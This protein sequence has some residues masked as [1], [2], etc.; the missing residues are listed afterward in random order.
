MSRIFSTT[1]FSL[2]PMTI[3]QNL[4][5]IRNT[6]TET[7]IDCGR[8][9][10]SIKLVAVS[11]RHSIACIEEAMAAKQYLFGE[12]YIQEAQE[13]IDS[14]PG[15]DFHFIGHIQSNKAKIAAELFSMIETVDRYKL[16]KA[17]NKHLEKLDREL[18]ILIQVNIGKDLNK[19][20]IAPEKTGE[21]L[22]QIRSFSRIHPLG[23]MTIP[24]FSTDNE[25]TRIHFQNL[26]LLSS[27][28]AE[29]GLF[30][31]NTKVELSMGMSHDYKIAIA[32]GA[33]II[34]VGTAIFGKRPDRE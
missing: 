24:P 19:S 20:G 12:N 33:T 27:E 14:L 9:P 30:A 23:L 1:G 8:D 5:T 16:A 7:A 34:R 31:D 25:E 6:I 28:L 21:F 18:N 22:Q 3:K 10:S 26:R 2:D 15:A 32:E 11:K 29:Q 4:Q 13:K 17:L